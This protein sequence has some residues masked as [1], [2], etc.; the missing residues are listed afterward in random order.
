MQWLSDD[1]F[2]NTVSRR[3]VGATD[4][5]QQTTYE[6]LPDIE[7]KIQQKSKVLNIL[8]GS[9]RQAH[10]TIVTLNEVSI[11]DELEI[12]GEWM[13]VISVESQT[14]PWDNVTTWRLYV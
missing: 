2:P 1:E 8:N 5:Y 9:E 3:K 10:F 14:S 7:C 12:N 11:G 13:V 6:A 4:L